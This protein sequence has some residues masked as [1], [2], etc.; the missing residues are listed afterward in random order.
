MVIQ[1]SI[2]NLT[3]VWFVALRHA[4]HLYMSALWR[5]LAELD[6]QGRVHDLDMVEI[7]LQHQILCPHFL[8]D[9]ISLGLRV[10]KEARHIACVD[11]L[12]QKGYAMLGEFG[13]GEREVGNVGSLGVR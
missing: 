3:S 4:R 8:E 10:G 11:S 5:I 7:H 12:D 1:K 9:V 2:V 13:C 6:S